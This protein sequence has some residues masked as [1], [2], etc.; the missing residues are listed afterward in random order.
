MPLILKLPTICFLGRPWIHENYVVPSTLH[1]CIK[2]IDKNSEVCRVFVVKKPF[3]GIEAYCVDARFYTSEPNGD[4]NKA[5]QKHLLSKKSK[6]KKKIFKVS[7]PPPAKL[8]EG[9]EIIHG[10]SSTK[11]ATKAPKCSKIGIRPKLKETAFIKNSLEAI[12]SAR[13]KRVSVCVISFVRENEGGGK[14]PLINYVKLPIPMISL[15]R[16]PE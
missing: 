4:A 3:K 14:E 15:Q 8:M 5:H 16:P 6:N 12:P 9:V 1:Q 13:L 10:E 11:V 2:Y 7:I